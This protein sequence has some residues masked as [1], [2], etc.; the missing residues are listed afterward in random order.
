MMNNLFESY[1]IS[2]LLEPF[3]GSKVYLNRYWVVK[4]NCVL[5]FIRTQA[6]QCNA[7]DAIVKSI[8]EDNPIY[9]DCSV[10][11]FQ[12]LYLPT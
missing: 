5:K 2:E 9:E 3:D 4:D 7:H 1:P 12:Y 8:M 10:V 11:F 6:W